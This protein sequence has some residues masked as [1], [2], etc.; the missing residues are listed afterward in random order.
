M[1]VLQRGIRFCEGLVGAVIKVKGDVWE[2]NIYILYH[3]LYIMNPVNRAG[4]V[5]EISPRHSSLS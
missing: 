5:S 1:D 3:N 4:T 2:V